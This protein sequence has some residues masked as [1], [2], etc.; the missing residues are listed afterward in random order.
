MRRYLEHLF[1]ITILAAVTITL[2]WWPF[3]A[4]ASN[5]Q[6]NT[7]RETVVIAKSGRAYLLRESA[8]GLKCD[9]VNLVRLSSSTPPTPDPEV[10]DPNLSAVSQK[11]V[12]LATPIG[13]PMI[14]RVFS[15]TYLE[16]AKRLES[17]SLTVGKA[18]RAVTLASDEIVSRSENKTQWTQLRTELADVYIKLAQEG[19]FTTAEQRAVVYRD[20]A[21]GFDRAA[22]SAGLFDK[23][24]L[25]KLIAWI[26]RII[27]I[28]ESLS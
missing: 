10:P 12:T 2:V 14:S 1:G 18:D 13:E 25:E 24:D 22:E 20:V 21:K 15:T 6:S 26:I 17:G 11:V 5:I 9:E 28:I 3:G 7:E 16:I 8:S 23:I 4:Q 27:E 19:K